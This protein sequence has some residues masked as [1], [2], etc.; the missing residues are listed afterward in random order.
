MGIVTGSF[1]SFYSANSFNF[2]NFIEFAHFIYGVKEA[3]R[4]AS[5]TYFLVQIFMHVEKLARVF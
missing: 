5:N 2:E 1:F 3:L 4:T